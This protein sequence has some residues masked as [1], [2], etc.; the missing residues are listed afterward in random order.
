ML[1]S[2][3]AKCAFAVLAA[4][5][6]LLQAQSFQ[7]GLRGMVADARAGIIAPAQI[8]LLDDVTNVMRSTLSNDAITDTQNRGYYSDNRIRPGSE[9][10]GQHHDAEMVEDAK[11]RHDYG[12]GN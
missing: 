10:P 8:T 6:G 3:P 1:T 2:I 9:G 11:S 5:V 12:G 7:G 4:A